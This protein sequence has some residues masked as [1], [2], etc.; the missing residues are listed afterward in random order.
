[1]NI[2]KDSILVETCTNEL[3]VLEFVIAGSHFGIN[4]A[5]VKE[6][7]GIRISR[8]FPIPSPA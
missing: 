3:E 4:V 5:K 7:I 2:R 8:G 1:M 6:L